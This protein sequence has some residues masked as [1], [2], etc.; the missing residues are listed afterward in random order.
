MI[1]FK[2]CRRDDKKM[3]AYIRI[4]TANK[5]KLSRLPVKGALRA[6]FQNEV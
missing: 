1:G 2:R 3:L 5:M 6:A 4:Y